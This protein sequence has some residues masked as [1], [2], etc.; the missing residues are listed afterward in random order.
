MV[1]LE[2]FNNYM[3]SWSNEWV[4]LVKINEVHYK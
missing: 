3:E 1:K 4:N 2:G